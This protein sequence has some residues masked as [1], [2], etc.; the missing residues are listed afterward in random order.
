MKYCEVDNQTKHHLFNLI[1]FI[2]DEVISSSGD[3]DFLWYSQIYNVKDIFCI[4]K[5]F[6]E[7]LKI[8]W[9][10]E[11]KGDKT[12]TASRGQEGFIITNDEEVYKNAPFWQQGLLKL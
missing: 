5:D 10:I 9:D 7:T 1:S 6:N 3:G 12:I 2:H 4:V 8:K 11:S